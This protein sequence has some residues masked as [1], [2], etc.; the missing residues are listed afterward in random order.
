[1][2]ISLCPHCDNFYDQDYNAEHEEE[3]GDY[4]SNFKETY[5]RENTPDQG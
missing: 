5:E 3:C 2:S 4:Q 1:M